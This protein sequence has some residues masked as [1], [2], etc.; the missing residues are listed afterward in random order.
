MALDG[1]GWIRI[2][3]LMVDSDFRL[4]L[5]GL[6]GIITQPLFWVAGGLFQVQGEGP[7]NDVK[8]SFAP[9]SDGHPPVPPTP[10]DNKKPKG[11]KGK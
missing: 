5:R 4:G 3:D 10:D 8:W 9:F 2:S 7:L 11:K 1:G 6:P